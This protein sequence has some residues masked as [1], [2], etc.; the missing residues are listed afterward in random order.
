[1]LFDALPG[2]FLQVRLHQHGVFQVLELSPNT[3]Q[4]SIYSRISGERNVPVRISQ[5]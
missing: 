2:T 3:L 1:M 5:P 4:R